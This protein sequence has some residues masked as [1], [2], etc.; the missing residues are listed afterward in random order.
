MEKRKGFLEGRGQGKWSPK[1]WG[2]VK[3][4][5]LPLGMTLQ[6]NGDSEGVLSFDPNNRAQVRMAIKIAGARPKRELNPEQLAD[7]QARGRRL[8]EL[9]QATV[10][11]ASG[12]LETTV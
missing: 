6:Q 9:R 4:A 7:L 11:T 8:A 10:K 2:N 5:A 12:G 1:K 3:R